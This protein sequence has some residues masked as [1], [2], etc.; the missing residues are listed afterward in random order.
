MIVVV[1]R[2]CGVVVDGVCIVVGV[3]VVAVVGV[4]GVVWKSLRGPD[5][6]QASNL[7]R[8][9]VSLVCR[10]PPRPAHW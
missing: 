10:L 6:T 9:C 7:T 2:V 4:L 1:I 8:I 3:A 5:K